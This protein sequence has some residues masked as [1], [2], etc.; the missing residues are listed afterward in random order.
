[1]VCYF[2]DVENIG[3]ALFDFIK[4]TTEPNAYYIIFYTN[5]VRYV[6]FSDMAALINKGLVINCF[7]CV[8]GNN[9]LDF[10]LCSEL[11]YRI[12]KYGSEVKYVI[13]SND[14]GYDSIIDYWYKRGII[15]ERIAPVSSS[16]DKMRKNNNFLV[17]VK[18]KSTYINILVSKGFNKRLAHNV[19][20][21]IE[22]HKNLTYD[23]LEQWL[24]KIL[25][26]NK[27]IQIMKELKIMF[28]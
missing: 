26:E 10:Q 2:F 20:S 28:K 12:G 3:N 19:I 18:D 16:K 21:Y 6:N 5:N 11:G 9:A 24:L 13:V 22:S 7:E 8:T 23:M 4:N 25:E 1:M 17:L 27:V 14:K 15:I